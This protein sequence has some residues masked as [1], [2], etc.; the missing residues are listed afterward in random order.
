MYTIGENRR[1]PSLF[2]KICMEWGNIYI[3]TIKHL[4]QEGGP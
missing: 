1:L 4:P 2:S 3:R